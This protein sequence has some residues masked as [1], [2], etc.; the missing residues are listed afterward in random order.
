MMNEVDAYIEKQKSPQK[1]IL[2]KVRRLILRTAKNEEMRWGVPTFGGGKFYIAGLRDSVNVGFS[3]SN[4]SK[5]DKKL[6]DGC[7]KFMGHVKITS[8]KELD[9]RRLAKLVKIV[10]KKSACVTC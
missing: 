6:L 9:V 3:I 1:E 2:K 4:M 7:G 8:L 5:E 10:D